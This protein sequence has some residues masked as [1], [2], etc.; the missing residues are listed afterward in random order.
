[1]LANIALPGFFPHS[2]LTLVG[3]LV[4]AAIEG[5]FLRRAI[6]ISYRAAYWHAIVANLKSTLV[7]IPVAWFFWLV[8][9]LPLWWIASV[10]GFKP[11]P[12]IGQTLGQTGM[13]GG[14]VPTE[15]S[16]L[17]AALAWIVLLVPFW[18]GSMWIECKVLRERLPNADAKALISAVRKG[19]LT[20]YFL[21]LVLG[22]CALFQAIDRLPED[23]REYRHFR[24][25]PN[26]K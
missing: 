10:V 14:F 22:L 12:L 1:M 16:N 21:F 19:N 6:P 9:L 8:G 15:W 2:L 23:Q 17:A 26:R 24:S 11:H 3:L 20:T 18:L 25:L 5:W 13:S 4:I 7:G